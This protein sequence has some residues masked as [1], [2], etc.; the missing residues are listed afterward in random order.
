MR[1]LSLLLVNI[2]AFSSLHTPSVTTANT[3]SN[4]PK[5]QLAQK[6]NC[7]NAQ[8][9]AVINECA[10]LSSQ[11]A[12]KKLNQVYQQLVSTLERSRKQKL[13]TAQQAWIKFRDNNCEFE[14]SKYEGGSIS[15]TIYFGC[16][17]NI[18]KLRTQQLR[19]YL[20]PDA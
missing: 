20:K 1:Y 9:Q 6:L 3:T 14:T 8:T 15:P 11:N 19:E 12:D 2:L 17:E 18:T 7:N 10:K 4:L 13:I 16:L 5:M